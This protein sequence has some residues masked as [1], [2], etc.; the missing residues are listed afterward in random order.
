M[1]DNWTKIIKDFLGALRFLWDYLH[2]SRSGPAWFMA[3]LVVSAIAAI[4]EVMSVLFVAPIVD[5]M[6][7]KQLYDNTP[8]MGD[9]VALFR[10]YEAHTRLQVIAL[11]MFV[12]VTLRGF[13]LFAASV[14]GSNFVAK[15][16]EE[17]TLPYYRDTLYLRMAFIN[18]KSYGYLSNLVVAQIGRVAEIIRNVNQIIFNVSL[19]PFYAALMLLISVPA[20]LGALGFS[21]TSLVFL[22]IVGKWQV[23]LSRHW[24]EAAID[25]SQHSADTLTSIKMLRL[26]TAELFAVK[27]FMVLMQ[28]TF[29]LQRILNAVNNI[30]GPL[31]T[32]LGGMLVAAL[33]LSGSLLFEGPSSEWLGQILVFLLVLT[34]MV[35]PTAGINQ[36]G[37]GIMQHVSALQDLMDYKQYCIK[38]RE[39][40]GNVPFD[41]LKSALKFENVSFGYARNNGEDKPVNWV[42]RDLSFTV[43][44]GEVVAVVGPSG[45]G[46]STIANLIARLYDPCEGRIVVDGN[47]LRDIE[48]PSW[49]RRLGFVTQEILLFNLSVAENLRFGR[50]DAGAD[51][52]VAAAKLAQAHGFIERMSCGYDSPVGQNGSL[53]SGGERQ[54]LAIARVLLQRPDILIL[55]EATSNLDSLTDYAFQQSMAT[56]RGTCTMI[57]IAHRLITVAA[58]DR[59]LVIDNG[60]L[61]ESGCHTELMARNGK[62]AEMVKHQTFSDAKSP[63]ES[64]HVNGG[65]DAI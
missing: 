54:R 52:V 36:A 29:K 65:M 64:S 13:A 1:L 27:R 62:Y 51:E 31:I 3:M 25:F 47:D 42:L 11:F 7:G 40:W 19:I 63:C 33:L 59:I 24:T 32:T 61:I 34:R 23:R 8:F 21:V 49:R 15:I 16:Q 28:R 45:A 50:P 20:T 57:V 10:G 39:T 43:H 22:R 46:K 12:F 48:L 30:N 53:L 4:T 44:P 35:G 38:E 14:L 18:D 5:L 58:A 41:G 37:L 9:F 26:A 2:S 17:I 55:D 60:E 6:S 56:L